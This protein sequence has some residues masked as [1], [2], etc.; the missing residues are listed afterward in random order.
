[1]KQDEIER[2]LEKI[3]PPHGA[4]NAVDVLADEF[5]VAAA[6]NRYAKKRYDRAVDAIISHDPSQV[7]DTRL[8]ATDSKSRQEHTWRGS[9]RIIVCICNSPVSRVDSAAFYNELLKAGV[10]RNILDDAK[11]KAT[12]TN[13]PATS[14]QTVSIDE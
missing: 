3:K 12:K 7:G 4:N 14:F 13:A 11:S 6:I 9:K 10:A 8:R 5:E 2:I 1:M